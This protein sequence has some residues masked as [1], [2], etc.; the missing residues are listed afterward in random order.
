MQAPWTLISQIRSHAPGA[1]VHLGVHRG[2]TERIVVVQLAGTPSDDDL[3]RLLY[4]GWPAPRFEGLEGVQGIE[5]PTLAAYRGRVL[6]LEFWAAWCPACRVI[7]PL[8]NRWSRRY[9][10]RN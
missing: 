6:L 1:R 4:V 3:L 7:A 10:K 2:R 8:M 5:Q 9:S